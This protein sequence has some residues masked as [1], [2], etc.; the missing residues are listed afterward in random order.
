MLQIKL[1]DFGNVLRIPDGCNPFKGR[2]IHTDTRHFRG[3][4]AY[5]PPEIHNG[6]QYE[7]MAADVWAMGLVMCH[8]V[9]GHM[10]FLYL[11]SIKKG[12]FDYDIGCGGWEA[13]LPVWYIV[14]SCLNMDH[15]W[16]PR[17]YQLQWR[18]GWMP[19]ALEHQKF[20]GVDWDI[21]RRSDFK[22]LVP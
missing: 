4:S 15:K 1:I 17:A 2:Y 9:V 12:R 20:I 7:A 10:P 13:L 16:R 6:E 21:L 18:E 3:T 22:Y 8:M 14:G 19:I 11:E 5:T